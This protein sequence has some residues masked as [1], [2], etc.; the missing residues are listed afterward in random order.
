VAPSYSVKLSWDAPASSADPVAS[1]DVYRVVS[2]GSSYTL[3]GSTTSGTTAYTDD[4]VSDGTT[5]VYYVVSVD[6][7][8]NESV[9]S[10]TYTAAI[11]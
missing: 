10:N 5:Y 6:A 4:S 8:G 11:P 9:P 3:V 1:Y 7:E 2:G